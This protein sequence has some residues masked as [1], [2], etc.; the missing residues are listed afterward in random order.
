MFK[1]GD[2]VIVHKPRNNRGEKPVWTSGMYKYDGI[3]TTIRR[4]IHKDGY[5]VM[6]LYDCGSYRFRDAWLEPVD[7]AEPYENEELQVFLSEFKVC[8]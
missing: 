8:G 1:V 6:L 7:T 4:I 2:L 5:D 3:E